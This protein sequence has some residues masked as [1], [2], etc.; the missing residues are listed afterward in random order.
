L[1]VGVLG[2]VDAADVVRFGLACRTAHLL[3]AEPSLWRALYLRRLSSASA[4]K[5]PPTTP[6]TKF[7]IYLI[8]FNFCDFKQPICFIY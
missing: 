8:L 7:I 1:W 6:A 5:V 2:W 3:A 4:T